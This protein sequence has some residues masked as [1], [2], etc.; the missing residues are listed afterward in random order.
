MSGLQRLTLTDAQGPVVEA[1]PLAALQ[2]RQMPTTTHFRRDHFDVPALDRRSWMLNVGGA[3]E[4]PLRLRLDDLQRLPRTSLAVVLECAGHRRAEFDPPARGIQWRIGAISEAVWSGARLR[5]LLELVGPQDATH[6]VLEGA[7]VG[8]VD[9]GGRTEAFARAIP[10]EKALHEDTLLAWEMNGE[11]LPAG[12][13][14]P[15]R[16]IVPGWY[17]TDSVKWLTTIRLHRGPYTGHFELNDYRLPDG[18]G[19]RRLTALPAS[20]LV[21]SHPDV[22]HLPPGPVRLRG[23]AWGGQDGIMR[24]HISINH[25]PWQDAQLEP[26]AGNYERHFWSLPWQATPGT[27]TLQTRAT[28]HTGNTQPSTPI[29]NERGFANASIHTIQ[30]RVG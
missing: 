17:A 27:H 12:H 19:S 11:P 25:G 14:A 5:D 16:A 10:L 13:G 15:L 24:V 21:T 2:L 9:D 18:T 4:R 3:V 1:A 7:D 26:G 8:A 30:L 28:D 23:I 6:V 29:W 20:S 22:A